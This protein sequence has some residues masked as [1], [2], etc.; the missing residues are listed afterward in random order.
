VERALADRVV[1]IDGAE[2]AGALP[3]LKHVFLVGDLKQPTPHPFIRDDRV[4]MIV[5]GYVA[6][7]DGEPHWH[8]DVTEYELVVEGEIGYVE[9]AT[10]QTHWFMAGDLVAIPARACVRRRVRQTARGVTVKVPSQAGKIR[11]DGC[12]R[13]C[14]SRVAPCVG[15]GVA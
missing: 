4:E 9:I 14:A 10:G 11:C 13:V 1:R 7:D 2:Y 5:V 3:A 15:V 12:A 8:A 6:G